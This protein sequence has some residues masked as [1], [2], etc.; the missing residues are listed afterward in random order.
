MAS[1]KY[2]VQY[3]PEPEVLSERWGNPQHAAKQK[4]PFRGIKAVNKLIPMS[5]VAQKFGERVRD[6]VA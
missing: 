6:Q 1:E 3:L 5:L 4:A 2:Q